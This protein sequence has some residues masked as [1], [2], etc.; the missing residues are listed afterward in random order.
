MIIRVPIRSRGNLHLEMHF[1]CHMERDAREPLA[2]IFGPGD[3]RRTLVPASTLGIRA[4]ALRR[5]RRRKEKRRPRAD[6]GKN[7]LLHPDR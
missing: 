5:L 6:R 3:G 4:A 7:D 1:S 2:T